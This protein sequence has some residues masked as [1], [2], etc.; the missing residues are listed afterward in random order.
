MRDVP[1][2]PPDAEPGD[3]LKPPAALPRE[4]PVPKPRRV[5]DAQLLAEIRDYVSRELGYAR[6]DRIAPPEAA[7]RLAEVSSRHLERVERAKLARDEFNARE[8][9]LDAG[10]PT[11]I[12]AA[13]SVDLS[14]LS[15]AELDA[16]AQMAAKIRQ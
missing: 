4:R 8:R 11:E 9:R 15:D 1:V 3:T 10:K 7:V 16:A 13:P 14:R 6:R 5:T 2:E 12:V